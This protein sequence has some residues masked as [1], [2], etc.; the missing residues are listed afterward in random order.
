M[1]FFDHKNLGNHL[2]RLCPKVVKHPVYNSKRCVVI[3]N[4]FIQIYFTRKS[5]VL[6]Y[7]K[8]DFFLFCD[9]RKAGSSSYKP[10]RFT[11][12]V[13]GWM[14]NNTCTFILNIVTRWKMSSQHQTPV[15]LLSARG[16]IR[17][18]HG[19]AG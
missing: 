18:I 1:N 16:I 10:R 11:P 14:R 5:F 8:F 17:N 2:L 3:E 6:P 7:K 9:V 12:D 4:S 19:M 13:W 15:T